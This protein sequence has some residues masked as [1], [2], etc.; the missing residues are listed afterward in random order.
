[1]RTHPQ[2][3]R[4]AWIVGLFAVL[5]SGCG[6][7]GL[8]DRPLPFS[9]GNGEDAI[10]V[11]V[12]M[13][14]VVNLVPNAEVKVNDVTVGSVR[15][16]EFND[17][18]ARLTIGLE[19]DVELPENTQARIG[20]KS[21]LGAEYLEL[22]APT[23]GEP[24]GRLRDGAT[25][26]LSSTGRYPETEELLAAVSTVLN[27]G[28]LHQVSTI[29]TELNQALSG[30][31]DDVSALIDELGILIGTLDGQR[32][33]IVTVLESLEDLAG[34][35]ADEE[36]RLVAALETLPVAVDVLRAERENLT[37]TLSEVADFGDQATDLL[38]DHQEALTRNL[39]NLQPVL[40]ELANA[41]TAL[42]NFLAGATFPFPLEGLILSA[43]GDYLNLFLTVDITTEAITRDLLAGIAPLDMALGGLTGLPP[44]TTS[45]GSA[46]P[47]D[48]E[49]ALAQIPEEGPDGEPDGVLDPPEDA[50]NEDSTGLQ[51]F[52]DAFLEGLL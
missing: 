44:T 47:L 27:G 32:D 36:P 33:Q 2:R 10:T 25:I 30:R 46:D 39:E 23:T 52:I 22:A 12:E 18:H 43:K 50:A 20:Q 38:V 21:L 13:E 34:T 31:E 3:L 1:M 29:T 42:T 35:F 28:G 7:S 45:T 49:G 48:L 9:K 37:S 4:W 17:W 24:V 40:A 11:I 8:N 15:R 41:D 26:P 14:N 19:G 51:T 16:I 5:V 6:M